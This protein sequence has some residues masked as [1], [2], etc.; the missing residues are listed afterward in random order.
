M[1]ALELWDAESWHALAARQVQFARE[2]GALVVLQLA[3]NFL[4]WAHLSAGELGTAAIMIDDDRSHRR[5][6]REPAGW[7]CRTVVRGLARP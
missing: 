5:G 1:I 2:T 6:D 3:V 4:A 7:V